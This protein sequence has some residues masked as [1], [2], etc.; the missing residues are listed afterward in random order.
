MCRHLHVQ[1]GMYYYYDRVW[2]LSYF[3]TSAVMLS[4]TTVAA[5]H[6]NRLQEVATKVIVAIPCA[7]VDGTLCDKLPELKYMGEITFP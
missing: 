7:S 4:H 2:Q 1:Q 3:L 6:C 5:S